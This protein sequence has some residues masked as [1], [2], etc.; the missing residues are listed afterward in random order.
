MRAG[1]IK[2]MCGTKGCNNTVYKDNYICST[3]K[4]KNGYYDN[5]EHKDKRVEYVFRNIQALD[6][7]IM[8]S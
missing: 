6:E 3:C 5:T 2:N 7:F 8:N 1:L 4:R